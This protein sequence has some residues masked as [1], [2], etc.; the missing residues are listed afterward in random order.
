MKVIVA[1]GR[2]FNDFDV[3]ANAIVES[4]F[5]I[6]EIV[7]GC[8][9]GVDTLGEIYA[10]E[11]DIPVKKFPADWKKNGR[12]AGPIR[13]GQMAE[14]ADAL[15]AVWDGV[16]RGTKNMIDQATARGRQVHV[17]TVNRP[18]WV[19]GTTNGQQP[20]VYIQDDEFKYDARLYV[21][22]DFYNHQQAIEYAKSVACKLNESEK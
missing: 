19:I 7:S 16:S 13:N 18:R 12:S 9:A 11:N 4:K 15:V 14:Y 17:H 21:D 22:G 2:D 20:R 6:T 3:V 1:G 5:I 10:A 8:A